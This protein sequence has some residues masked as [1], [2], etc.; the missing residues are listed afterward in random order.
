[1]EKVKKPDQSF[2][3]FSPVSTPKIFWNSRRRSASGRNLDKVTNQTANQ[4]P[5]KQEESPNDNDDKMEESDATLELSERRKALFEPLEPVKNINGR[6]PF[7]ESLLPPPDFDEATYPKGWLIGKKRKLVNVDV[8]ES[9]RRIAVQEMN[10][11]DRE[12]DGLN[13]QLEEDARCLEHLQVQLLQ[14]RSKRAE[15]ER[16]NAVLQDQV[17]MLMNML[18]ENEQLGDEGAADEDPDQP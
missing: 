10:R 7:A 16:E 17:S 18:Q 13:E 11:K 1:M 8:V 3:G 9:M 4:T 6:R 15:V 2:D 5:T 14:E 12:I